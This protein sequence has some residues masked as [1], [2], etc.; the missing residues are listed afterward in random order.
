[1]TTPTRPPWLAFFFTIAAQ[2][3][4]TVAALWWLD[5][6]QRQ[7][8]KAQGKQALI[9]QLGSPFAATAL[10]AL[11]LI[12]TYGYDADGSLRGADLVG[13][14]LSLEKYRENQGGAYP[15]HPM[16][17]ADLQAAD[18]SRAKL[19]YAKLAYANLGEALLEESSFLFAEMQHVNMRYARCKGCDL[20]Y[21]Q[22][23]AADLVNCD[24][25]EANMEYAHLEGA[26]LGG[27]HMVWA[28]LLGTHLNG[29]SMTNCNL[30]GANFTYA[31]LT[32]ANLRLS[33]LGDALFNEY[34]ILPDGSYWQP[35]S[36][37]AVFTDPEHPQAW[38]PPCPPAED[39]G[40][41][42]YP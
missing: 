22:L 14:A 29:A 2:G 6:R 33:D 7:R 19:N 31:D 8:H 27:S 38:Q 21:A 41:M 18:L 40:S 28:R 26:N 5:Q 4:S 10:N 16:K 11:R 13:A 3:L 24:L 35:K 30:R 34:T 20:S 9:V 17:T 32:D 23:K 37:M 39:P 42:G 36:D 25:F 1:M 12:K 15:P